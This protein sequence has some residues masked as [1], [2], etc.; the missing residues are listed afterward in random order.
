MG[1]LSEKNLIIGET[2]QVARYLPDSYA[3]VSSRNIPN[4]IYA[5]KWDKVFLCFA[6]QRTFLS[7]TKRYKE[8]FYSINCDL[9]LEL[10]E[11]IQSKKK[12]FFS[13]SEL[14]NNNTGP[15][16]MN[17]EWNY[18]ENYYTDSKRKIT[19]KVMGYEDVIT[20]FPF[21][22]NSSYRREGFLFGKI[23]DSIVSRKKI[24]V[25]DLN[26]HRDMMHPKYFA[27]QV[28]ISNESCLIGAGKAFGVREYIM[29]LYKGM[30]MDVSEYLEE[31]KN[32]LKRNVFYAKIETNYEYE[33]LLKDTIDDLQNTTR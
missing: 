32:N 23:F 5:E 9:T 18:R 33:D 7:N 21:N 22:Y 13:T 19:E 29:D 28:E 2:S 27:Q 24:K 12:V 14:W 10:I 4:S 3:R 11:K 30:G 25:G 6:E 26:F 15:I 1:K 8:E 16:S 20:I 31:E 17:D